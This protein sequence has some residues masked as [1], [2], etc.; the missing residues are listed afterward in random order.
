MPQLK[1]DLVAIVRAADHL[2]GI[3]GDVAR[4][5]NRLADTAEMTGHAELTAAVDALDGA[6][7]RARAA[8]SEDLAYV[9][10][11]LVAVAESFAEID[12]GLARSANRSALWSSK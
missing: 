4:T 11:A 8:L 9:T 12:S 2:S 10:A 1:L 7:A 6:W 3:R 5:S